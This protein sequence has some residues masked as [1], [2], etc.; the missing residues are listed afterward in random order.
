VVDDGKE[1]TLISS[2]VKKFTRDIKKSLSRHSTPVEIPYT[3]FEEEKSDEDEY[4]DSKCL[5]YFKRKS[6]TG[7]NKLFKKLKSNDNKMDKIPPAIVKEFKKI[8]PVIERDI[9]LINNEII[10]P[11]ENEII[12]IVIPIVKREMSQALRTFLHLR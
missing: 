11:I 5:D 12:P 7:I 8:E 2:K 1:D 6:I 9:E 4:K 10:I 3:I